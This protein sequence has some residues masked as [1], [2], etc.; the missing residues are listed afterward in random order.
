[1]PGFAS[2]ANR[3]GQTRERIE[4]LL[5]RPHG[6]MPDL[7]LTHGEVL[8]LLAYFESLRIDPSILPLSPP[9]GEDDPRPA[10]GPT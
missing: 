7:H 10:F 5:T 3:P 9:M 4:S 6:S 8:D 2:I 1:M